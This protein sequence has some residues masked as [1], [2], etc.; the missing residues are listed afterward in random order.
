MG[1]IIKK[2]SEAKDKDK[3]KYTTLLKYMH[4]MAYMSNKTVEGIITS[5]QQSLNF[6]AVKEKE[7]VKDNQVGFT[8]KNVE[9][10]RREAVK[11]G[12]KELEKRATELIDTLPVD[13]KNLSD[14]LLVEA[15]SKEVVL[16]QAIIGYLKTQPT[17]GL[18]ID[19]YRESTK[20]NASEIDQVTNFW[21][22]WLKDKVIQPG[23]S[24][25]EPKW[26]K[27]PQECQ[28]SWIPLSI[29]LLSDV[30][31]MIKQNRNTSLKEYFI[32]TTP[33]V[34]LLIK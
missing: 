25:G 23:N 5:A 32:T 8:L 24:K 26:M 6:G 30:T 4:L 28:K 2:R 11:L 12:R 16:G 19:A 18:S 20:V 10:E 15:N 1:I 33:E 21:N 34:L 9:R 27:S 17:S 31:D 14:Y 29:V 3:S 7:S 13:D 22:K